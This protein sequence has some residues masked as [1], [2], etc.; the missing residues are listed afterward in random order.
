MFPHPQS[1]SEDPSIDWL[2][3]M[4]DVARTCP[5]K[6]HV[7]QGA[8]FKSWCDSNTPNRLDPFAD[9]VVHNVLAVGKCGA[10]GFKFSWD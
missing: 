6:Q 10:L 4:G 5:A 9:C 7:N 1:H 3:E 2:G 8:K